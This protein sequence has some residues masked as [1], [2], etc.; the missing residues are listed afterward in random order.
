MSKKNKKHNN[1]NREN[2]GNNNGVRIHE[3]ALDFAK[4]TFKKYKKKYADDY[5]SK[6]EVKAGYHIFLTDLLPKAIEFVVKYGYL[7]QE[8][9]Q[10]TKEAIFS[11]LTDEDYV[12][13][14]KK[15]LK[16]GEKVENI[17][18]LPIVIKE[19]VE[20]T[21]KFNTEQLAN[22]PNA[23]VIDVSDLIELSQIIMK[24]K[25]KKFEK[26]GVDTAL[27]FDILS[28]IPKDEVLTSSQNYR[29]H[30]LMDVLYEH[31]KSKTIPYATIMDII[32]G[33]EFYPM[34]VVFALLE[35]K[36]KFGTLTDAQKTLYLDI[37][38][39][40]FNT[41][42]KDLSKEQLSEVINTYIRSRRRDESQNKDGNRRY[43]LSTLSETDYP[44][45]S[46]FIKK[47]IA[48]DDTLQKYL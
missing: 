43:A 44:R 16:E 18:L 25:L 29:I 15:L 32:V 2:N 35:R 36:E 12:K 10:E 5:D 20:A 6:K 13:F 1:E 39:W 27:A 28:V 40:V 11:K 46:A 33:E 9:A 30:L 34:F 14:L 3:D 31:A 7:K 42:E 45:I 21:N 23:E 19:I 48:N 37:S 8:E 47:M 26:E 4:I 38:N 24:K 41:M 17:K 22:N